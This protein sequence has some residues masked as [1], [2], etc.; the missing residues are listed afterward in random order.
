M[1]R[2]LKS[3]ADL[4]LGRGGFVRRLAAVYAGSSN[5]SVSGAGTTSNARLTR[6]S[7]PLSGIVR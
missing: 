5:C 3:A 2:R 6:V 7:S 4:E 1:T